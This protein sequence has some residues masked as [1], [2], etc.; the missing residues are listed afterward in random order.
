[1]SIVKYNSFAPARGFKNVF[2]DFFNRNLADYFGNEF[3]TSTP[4]AN[5]VEKDD[6]YWIEVAA[7]GLEKQD[8]EVSVDKG[9]L[10]ISAKRENQSETKDEH[11]A[12]RE[13]NYTSFQRSFQ[14]PEHVNANDIVANYDKGV[15]T[16]TLP[17]REEA[18]TGATRTIEIK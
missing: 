2:D 14:L 12:R 13:F 1:M 7:P 5:V 11:Y 18:K 17:K 8:F 16:I 9:Y 4:S 10:N 15:L 3:T 6:H